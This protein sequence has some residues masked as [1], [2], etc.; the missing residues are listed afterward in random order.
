MNK[1]N[2]GFVT[3]I[4]GDVSSELL[5]KLYA[6]KKYWE[7]ADKLKD[8][9]RFYILQEEKNIK[10][11]KADITR[12]D[13]SMFFALYLAMVSLILK[14]M[15]EEPKIEMSIEIRE[16]KERL[17]INLNKYGEA[18]CFPGKGILNEKM[19]LDSIKDMNV[20][21]INMLHVNMGYFI[22]KKIQ[23]L[24]NQDV[25]PFAINRI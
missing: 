3:K 1:I 11:K 16:A 23:Q 10:L 21:S 12:R 14:S 8:Q 9:Y 24:R 4:E 13:S 5:N 20:Q 18:I 2:K 19:F 7:W 6:L 17:G 25:F 22:D 15:D